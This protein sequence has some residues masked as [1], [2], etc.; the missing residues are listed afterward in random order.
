[1][2]TDSVIDIFDLSSFEAV[3]EDIP[4]TKY[5]DR[6]SLLHSKE[7]VIMTTGDQQQAIMD[8]VRWLEDVG[9]GVKEIIFVRWDARGLI[10]SLLESHDT[11]VLLRAKLANGA[12]LNFFTVNEPAQRLL[13]ALGADLTWSKHTVN[14]PP[15]FSVN[16]E[17][18]QTLYQRLA[19][20]GLGKIL[21]HPRYFA[22]KPAEVAEAV[23]QVFEDVPSA[24]I[25]LVS[26]C[27]LGGG[28]GTELVLRRD[29]FPSQTTERHVFRWTQGGTE[30]FLVR[31]TSEASQ[32]VGFHFFNGVPTC[33]SFRLET[34]RRIHV[35]SALFR[36]NLPEMLLDRAS[37]L[38]LFDT[39]CEIVE[40]PAATIRR[41]S[42]AVNFTFEDHQWIQSPREAITTRNC[43]T[44][45]LRGINVRNLSENFAESVAA[46]VWGPEWP[47]GSCVLQR[48]VDLPAQLGVFEQLKTALGKEYLYDPQRKQGAIPR[49]PFPINDAAYPWRT[50]LIFLAASFEQGMSFSDNIAR[51]LC[52]RISG[53]P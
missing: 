43:R 29:R 30:V 40:T 9:L 14:V 16:L 11:Q 42:L 47:E 24:E 33:V 13:K 35:G 3:E 27:L 52:G 50:H 2:D 22:V 6:W 46:R 49:L 28:A 37:Y 10:A 4:G 39:A 12:K 19:E 45:V 31:P 34:P 36:R 8:Y 48:G 51:L 41:G 44:A 17:F 7:M 18:P 38:A 25:V 32:G 1:M 21:P 5:Y 26:P 53:A 15:E 20:E 23:R